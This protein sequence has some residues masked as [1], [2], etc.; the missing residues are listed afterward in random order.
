MNIETFPLKQENI[1]DNQ[2]PQKIRKRETAS[3]KKDTEITPENDYIVHKMM[4]SN[5]HSLDDFLLRQE[6]FNDNWEKEKEEMYRIGLALGIPENEIEQDFQRSK[7]IKEQLDSKNKKWRNKISDEKKLEKIIIEEIAH[8]IM[9]AD[10]ESSEENVIPR[11][12]MSYDDCINKVDGYIIIK[13][14]ILA[15]DFTTIRDPQDIRKKVNY[16]KNSL[17]SNPKNYK[18]RNINDEKECKNKKQ[19]EIKYFQ[20]AHQ[21]QKR[22]SPINNIPKIIINIPG[23]WLNIYL[24]AL[25]KEKQYQ[26]LEAAQELRDN[27]DIQWRIFDSIKKQLEDQ[28]LYLLAKTYNKIL[29]RIRIEFERISRQKRA[30]QIEDKIIKIYPKEN[31]YF[32]KFKEK[33]RIT[34]EDMD[35]INRNFSTIY[36]EIENDNY[37]SNLCLNQDLIDAKEKIDSLSKMYEKMYSINEKIRKNKKIEDN[38]FLIDEAEKNDGWEEQRRN[39]ERNRELNTHPL[40]RA[41]L[42]QATKQQIGQ[43]G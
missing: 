37:L 14:M 32:I 36:N 31:D 20:F 43:T 4:N 17:D 30:S 28:L 8:W 5:V 35:D 42:E 29:T 9:Q 19:S 2:A 40:Y 38:S 26:G 3:Q 33:N 23:E 11:S 1:I 34:K 7:R 24:G 18:N 25:N 27:N 10:N 41:F 16:I 39:I 13:E 6:Q 12:T 22:K 21:N 15:I